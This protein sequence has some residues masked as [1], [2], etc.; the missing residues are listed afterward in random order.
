MSTLLKAISPEV[1]GAA[2]CMVLA[3]S[4]VTDHMLPDCAAFI[5]STSVHNFRVCMGKTSYTPVLRR[6][7]VI[8]SLNEK[9]LLIW[10]V[11]HVLV[12]RVPFCSLRA[13]IC[14]CGCRF[15]GIFDTGMHVYFPGVV[16]CLDT[17]TNCH[18]SY[19]S[20]GKLVLL[21]SLQYV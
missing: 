18:L 21:S 7:T 11:L 1:L 16:L 17:S 13:H 20:L 8:I 19:A 2:L 12:L 10:N 9:H 5:S 15:L 3:D 14:N 4:G 6:G